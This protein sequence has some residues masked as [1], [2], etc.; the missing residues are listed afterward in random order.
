M[1]YEHFAL[2]LVFMP[3]LIPVSP[4]R[5]TCP[6]NSAVVLASYAVQ[7]KSQREHC[8]GTTVVLTSILRKPSTSPLWVPIPYESCGAACLWMSGE[9]HFY[10]DLYSP[11]ARE[12]WIKESDAGER[13][14]WA[15]VWHFFPREHIRQQTAIT[16]G[17]FQSLCPGIW[18]W[19]PYRSQW[20]NIYTSHLL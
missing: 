14:G 9:S 18:S 7:C 3:L 19:P 1:I 15:L 20:K 5:L 4:D 6:L 16:N 17:V 13:S 12:C 8:T 10:P 2:L 11:P